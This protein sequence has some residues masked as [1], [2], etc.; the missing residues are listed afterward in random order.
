MAIAHGIENICEVKPKEKREK[1]VKVAKKTN[2]VNEL[3]FGE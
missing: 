2:T 3:N 1:A